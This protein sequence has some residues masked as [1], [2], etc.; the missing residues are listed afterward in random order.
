[1]EAGFARVARHLDSL[2]QKIDA[3][4]AFARG[5]PGQHSTVLD[6]HENRLRDLE[7]RAMG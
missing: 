1:M 2:N 6:E 4:L 3:V 5:Q 7:T